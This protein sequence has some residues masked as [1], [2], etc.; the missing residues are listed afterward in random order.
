MATEINKLY[1]F[2]YLCIVNKSPVDYLEVTMEQTTC[3]SLA[4]TH[5]AEMKNNLPLVRGA[6]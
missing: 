3:L 4:G 5:C 1:N 6:E 2:T